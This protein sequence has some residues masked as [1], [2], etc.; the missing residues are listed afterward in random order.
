MSDATVT[1]IAV[2]QRPSVTGQ[3]VVRSLPVNT[4][5]GYLIRPDDQWTPADLRDYVVDKIVER[6]G[7]QFPR[8]PAKEMSI[9][10][11][12]VARYQEFSGAIARYAFDGPDA[13][14]WCNA[15]IGIERFCK[16][17]DLWFANKILDSLI[18]A[19]QA[20]QAQELAAAEA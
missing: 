20:A 13:G 11:A 19:A 4:S 6:D 8:N 15:P 12:F 7:R 18:E 9:F 1:R 3:A 16:G 14:W 2:N 17:S 10:T 5:K